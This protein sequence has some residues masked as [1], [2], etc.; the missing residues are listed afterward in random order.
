MLRKK[1]TMKDKVT[2]F[3][4]GAAVTAG[5]V[6]GIAA[7]KALSD[8]K[9]RKKL[10]KEITSAKK[11]A[12]KTVAEVVDKRGEMLDMVKVRAE[13]MMPKKELLRQAQDEKKKVAKK[14]SSAKRSTALKAQSTLKKTT[15]KS[16]K[17]T[18]H[19]ATSKSSSVS[20]SK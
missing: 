13:K 2:P 20:A 19:V 8:K 11:Q 1:P 18:N 4:A 3:A 10:V 6:V 7:A 16:P 17:K 9:T 5:A 14:V 15:K 12:S